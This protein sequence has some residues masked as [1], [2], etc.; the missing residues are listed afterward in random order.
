VTLTLVETPGIEIG[1]SVV[2]ISIEDNDV[3]TISFVDAYTQVLEGSLATLT[4]RLS[5]PP[6]TDQVVY[7]SLME[8]KKADYALDYLTQP[9]AEGLLMSVAIPA[10]SEEVSFLFNALTDKKREFLEL[11]TFRLTGSSS[12]VVATSPVSSVV[13][14]ENVR[15]QQVFM[16][17]P[18]PT[19]DLIQLMAENVDDDEVL[20]AEISEPN[21][22]M[23]VTV[24][25]TLDEL[26][27]Q[28]RQC[29]VNRRKGL[30][31][32]KII[33]EA[34]TMVLRIVKL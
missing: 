31:T 34:E 25:A 32:L 19:N 14:I 21:G 18:N 28:I 27:E 2:T 4:L 26:N 6:I 23:V 7:V 12:G 8:E 17:Y 22:M 10:G 20:T 24:T 29:L 16:I 3:P 13:G 5:T 11:V 1:N 15:N 30:Y 33:S 9:S